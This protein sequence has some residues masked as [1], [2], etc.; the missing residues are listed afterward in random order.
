MAKQ[1]RIFQKIFAEN[2]GLAQVG[3]FGSLAAGSPQTT[4]DLAQVQSLSQFRGGWFSAVLGNNSPAIEDMNALFYLITAQ[5]SYLFMSG[6]PEWSAEENYFIDSIVRSGS[7]LYISLTDD[8][9]NNALTDDT[10]WV[11][12]GR[13]IR[14]IS[15]TGQT[16]SKNDDTVLFQS[17]DA[18][19]GMDFILP[20][21]ADCKGKTLH[22][23]N[24]GTGLCGGYGNNYGVEKIDG[25]NE[26]DIS[27]LNTSV[28]LVCDGLNWFIF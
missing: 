15:L 6:I 22:L 16:L 5:L 28:V 8:N 23:K 2:S 1:P 21:A 24:I 3:K 20:P 14:T 17:P 27:G 11:S 18:P 9:I 7:T 19:M 25:Q 26:V 10:K 12:L 4:M 13:N